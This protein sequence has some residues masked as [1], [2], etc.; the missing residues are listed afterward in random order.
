MRG[1]SVCLSDSDLIVVPHDFWQEFLAAT[2]DRNLF[3]REDN[4]RRAFQYFDVEGTGSITV[5]NLVAIFGSEDHAREI[6]GKF[7]FIS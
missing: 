7:L 4:V 6:V 3:I 1:L 2:I 5:A